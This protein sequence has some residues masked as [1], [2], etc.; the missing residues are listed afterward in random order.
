[1]GEGVEHLGFDVREV[2][3]AGKDLVDARR[4]GAPPAKRVISA[5]FVEELTRPLHTATPSTT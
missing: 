2:L 5:R 3:C 4:D 1:M